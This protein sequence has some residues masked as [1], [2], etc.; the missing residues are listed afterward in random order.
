MEFKKFRM[1]GFKSFV[2]PVE[3]DILPG[4]TGIVGPNGCGKSNLVESLRWVMGEAST[5]S[6]RSKQM[7][8]VIFA[9][10]SLRSARDIAEVSVILNNKAHDAPAPH[11][12]T[13]IIEISR[14]IE[15]DAGSHYQINGGETRARDVNMFFADLLGGAHSSALVG[16]G[17]IDQIILSKPKERRRILEEAAGITGL[18][19]RRHEAQLRL[20]RAED[21]LA[22]LADNIKQ[23]ESR[24]RQLKKQATQA[25]RYRKTSAEIER[26]EA[27]LA[28]TRWRQAQDELAQEEQ[29]LID[30]KDKAES[31]A[32]T[33]VQTRQIE[34]QTEKE[35]NVAREKAAEAASAHERLESQKALLESEDRALREKITGLARAQ[36]ELQDDIARTQ[37][38]IQDAQNQLTVLN[39]EEQD[40][41]EA[42]GQQNQ[43][44]QKAQEVINAHQSQLA[45]AES[46]AE[47]AAKK[48]AD[49]QSHISSLKQKLQEIH[50][51]QMEAQNEETEILSQ[52]EE[53]AGFD[54]DHLEVSELKNRADAARAAAH[55]CE[56]D[57][58]EA[59]KTRTAAA[60]DERH[61]HDQLGEARDHVSKCETEVNAMGKLFADIGDHPGKAVIDLIKGGWFT[62]RRLDM[63]MAAALGDDL[64]ASLEEGSASFWR[65]SQKKEKRSFFFRRR[66]EFDGDP[67]LPTHATPL[68]RYIRKPLALRRRLAQVGLIE[69]T[70]G[71]ELQA[72]LKPGQ[73]L[74]SREGHLWRWDGYTADPRIAKATLNRLAEWRKFSALEAEAEKARKTQ[75]DA[76]A[77]LD[78]ARGHLETTS[79]NL[80][81]AK[82]QRHEANEAAEQARSQWQE[83]AAKISTAMA[84]KAALDEAAR[85]LAEQ[86][87]AATQ[88]IEETK[89]ALNDAENN[90]RPQQEAEQTRARALKARNALST[91]KEAQALVAQNI[92]KQQQRL[93]QI[94]ES[95]A[96]AD[97]TLAH[98]QQQIESST[99]RLTAARQEQD[100]MANK[101]QE[102]AAKI[103]AMNDQLAATHQNHEQAQKALAQTEAHYNQKRNQTREAEKTLARERETLARQETIQE[104][105]A[106]S[107]TERRAAIEHKYNR[108]PDEIRAW[109]GLEENSPIPAPSEIESNLAR[110]EDE[111][112]RIGAPNLQAEEERESMIDDYEQLKTE[113]DDLEKAINRLR[114]GI[115]TLNREGRER[116]LE[117]F[118]QVNQHFKVLFK[119]LFGGGSARLELVD[120]EDPLE[121]GLEI[122]ARPP[123]KAVQN[124]S[125][126]S[127]G[128]KAL[129]AISLL[130][131]AFKT[132]PA[133]IC[134]LDEVDAPL[135]DRNVQRFCDLL[136]EM[137]KHHQ[138]RFLVI[139]HH[140]ITLS[141]MD[142]LYGVTMEEEGV[143]RIV[144]V[145]L[146][147]AEE[148][149][150]PLQAVG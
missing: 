87:T 40:I 16:Q 35:F 86:K 3:L 32:Q 7:D 77:K 130:F 19:A 133:P 70:R 51:R 134:V 13:D 137:A 66:A 68:S 94:K 146:A 129:T 44:T 75:N 41:I 147:E 64:M 99:Q 54:D 80:E 102:I 28:W 109:A 91:A 62:N 124:M 38:M 18:H 9:G 108:A 17:R 97:K 63:A 119:Q 65:Q 136:D 122:I 56:Q 2:E 140:A 12:D 74:V 148:M 42:Q 82:T 55:L 95:R 57:L 73:R 45:Q 79:Q 76:A 141:R 60:Q 100:I 84:R 71:D 111:R 26:M 59:E 31:C 49:W 96:S 126:L 143:S 150:E 113:T 117:A 145:E 11:K 36:E 138:T 104:N 46:E 125:L 89:A 69:A 92:A 1:S 105:A 10:T 88:Q 112:T 14:H 110:L 22:K 72:A 98:F 61:A 78:Q 27:L 29:K 106:R 8:D 101:P 37:N 93:S 25:E 33:A 53:F 116:L 81:A 52:L 118:E 30:T 58:H 85:R 149:R 67:H 128:E 121:A 131:A 120:E 48:H 4:L 83:A 127:G 114:R 23:T 90:P 20:K 15:R 123:G 115:S 5:K 24:L 144:S 132:R 43:E 6:L 139:T 34:L 21:N 107:L 142:R 39:K 47:T 50:K 103:H 135:D